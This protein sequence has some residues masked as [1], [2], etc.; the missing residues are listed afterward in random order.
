MPVVQTDCWSL[1]Q[2]TVMWLPN[3]LGWVDLFTHGALLACALRTQELHYELYLWRIKI[4]NRLLAYFSYLFQLFINRAMTC[5][6]D[7]WPVTCTLYLPNF[8]FHLNLY[9]ISWIY[10]MIILGHKLNPL[11]TITNITCYDHH[12]PWNSLK[13]KLKLTVSHNITCDQAFFCYKRKED[14][15]DRN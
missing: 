5:T 12:F 4:R 10:W 3:F 6:C 9:Q 13:F 15:P 14:P 2:C 7:L 11:I 8:M 1:V